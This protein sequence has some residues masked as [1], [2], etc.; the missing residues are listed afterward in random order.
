MCKPPGHA[1]TGEPE[2]GCCISASQPAGPSVVVGA[3]AA[4]VCNG[5]EGGALGRLEAHGADATDRRLTLHGLHGQLSTSCRRCRCCC[6]CCC[7]C[8][9]PPGT[10]ENTTEAADG[11]TDGRSRSTS[12]S[13]S[14][15]AFRMH[16]QL[17]RFFGRPDDSWRYT[18]CRQ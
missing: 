3:V 16:L 8:S 7:Y 1:P 10:H 11:W 6:F 14:W 18:S 2:Q 15:R 9:V 5:V 12:L 4:V 17:S 13:W